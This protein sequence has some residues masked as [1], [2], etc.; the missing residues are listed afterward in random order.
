MIYSHQRSILETIYQPNSII[1]IIKT[2]LCWLKHKNLFKLLCG[3]LFRWFFSQ[4]QYFPFFHL[5]FSWMRACCRDFVINSKR[6]ECS[7][8]INHSTSK[9]WS[10]SQFLLNSFFSTRFCFVF[11]FS[12]FFLVLFIFLSW[13][14]SGIDELIDRFISDHNS[15]ACSTRWLHLRMIN[16]Q[17]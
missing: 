2:N 16:S 9:Y 11:L 13:C 4:P 12:F 8:H 10:A 17:I 5:Y 14:G 7:S 1:A 3:Y 6:N 15:T